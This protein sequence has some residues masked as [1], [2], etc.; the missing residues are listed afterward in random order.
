MPMSPGVNNHKEK[1]QEDYGEPKAEFPRWC[2]VV[3][4]DV[5][6]Y[7]TLEHIVH[8]AFSHSDVGNIVH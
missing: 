2:R 4:V 3:N 8:V 1:W 6:V 5:Y 7:T